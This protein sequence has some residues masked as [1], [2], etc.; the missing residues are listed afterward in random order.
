[1]DKLA[2]KLMSYFSAFIINKIKTTK[3]FRDF[4][5]LWRRDNYAVKVRDMFKAAVDDAKEFLYLPDQLIEDLLND[6]TNRDEIFRWI[7]EGVTLE[8]FKS[9]NLN[10]QPYYENYREYQD[11]I[12]PFFRIILNKVNEYRWCCKTRVKTRSYA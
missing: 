6:P 11:K 7:V 2:E 9:D 3:T 12:L 8:D 1:M 5:R 4:Q 10:L